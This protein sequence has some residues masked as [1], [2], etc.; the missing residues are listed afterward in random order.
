MHP[1]RW[2]VNGV[3]L[4]G[5]ASGCSGSSPK[6]SELYPVLDERGVITYRYVTP[7]PSTPGAPSP[8]GSPPR[9]TPQDDTEERQRQR[10]EQAYQTSQDWML[11]AQQDRQRREQDERA[12]ASAYQTRCSER[13]CVR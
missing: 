8:S 1:S 5:F 2:S 9:Q 13:T 3:A 6:T 10:N 7:A 11:K 4:L 12:R